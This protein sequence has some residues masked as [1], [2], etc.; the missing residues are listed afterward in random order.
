MKSTPLRKLARRQ[1]WVTIRT[2]FETRSHTV[3]FGLCREINRLWNRNDITD[4]IARASGT[5]MT[6]DSHFPYHRL[7]RRQHIPEDRS[8]PG[9]VAVQ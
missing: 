2:V 8:A 4:R 1:A 7:L 3:L 9:C 6:T 5:E